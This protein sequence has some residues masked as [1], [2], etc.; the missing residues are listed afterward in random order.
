MSVRFIRLA[1]LVVL[2]FLA[3]LLASVGRGA[4]SQAA[5]ASNATRTAPVP[6]PTPTVTAGAG[7]TTGRAW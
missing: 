5:T 6:P 1:V 2:A 7:R 3:S 4:P